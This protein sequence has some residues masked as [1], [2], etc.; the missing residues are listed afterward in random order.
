ME[1]D[2]REVAGE[3]LNRIRDRLS[4]SA[5]ST[6]VV[7]QF[8]IVIFAGAIIAAAKFLLDVS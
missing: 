2:A 1:D 7:I 3:E 8:I 6:A 5:A 4:S